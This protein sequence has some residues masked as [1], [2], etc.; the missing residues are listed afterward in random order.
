[1]FAKIRANIDDAA[2]TSISEKIASFM[3]A[4]KYELQDTSSPHETEIRTKFENQLLESMIK[5]LKS[6]QTDLDSDL[7]C[8]AGEDR[9][10]SALA[11][12][13]WGVQRKRK[14]REA[15]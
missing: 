13:M 15:A 6:N 1:M 10:T 9:L 3:R 4:I 14:G 2:M 12:L 11:S 7:S 5:Q 8:P